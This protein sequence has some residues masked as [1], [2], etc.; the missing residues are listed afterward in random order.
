MNLESNRPIHLNLIPGNCDMNDTPDN[1]IEE[2]TINETKNKTNPINPNSVIIRKKNTTEVVDMGK[3]FKVRKSTDKEYVHYEQS[4]MVHF[5]WQP[6]I[7]EKDE[8]DESEIFI[9]TTSATLDVAET[10]T[11]FK[12]IVEPILKPENRTFK[13]ASEKR[14][15][16][17]L[18]SS[19]VSL[20]ETAPTTTAT[21]TTT[22]TTSTSTNSNK[23]VTVQLFP[24]RFAD[25]FE[26]AER[27]ARLTIL[28]LLTEQFPTIF[29]SNVD[30]SQH[31]SGNGYNNDNGGLDD[32]DENDDNKF[33]YEH[34]TVINKNLTK[35]NNNNSNSNNKS[36]ERNFNDNV[37]NESLNLAFLLE[38]PLPPI[39]RKQQLTKRS[40][41]SSAVDWMTPMKNETVRIDLPTYK[42]PTIT[43]IYPSSSAA[44]LS[45]SS[46]SSSSSAAAAP[47]ISAPSSS[48]SA[49][50][51]SKLGLVKQNK[52][53][54]LHYMDD[55]SINNS[56]NNN[57]NEEK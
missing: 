48:A 44:A 50:S 33:E 29:R 15:F 49:T 41:S 53:I 10:T 39:P 20:L 30:E 4:R 24:Y 12:E 55:D 37:S 16:D 14:S 11:E 34:L 3:H 36:E 51:A 32:D 21:T 42:P 27:Y 35:L 43:Y 57:N 13:R 31:N 28:P 7:K 45:T 17:E 22:M 56:Y 9:T 47:A 18:P 19:T 25:V 1:D 2:D 8:N 38:P 26:K 5:P 54:P 52:F 23:L 6:I 46:S 40:D